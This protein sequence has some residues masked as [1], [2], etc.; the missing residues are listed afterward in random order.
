M[1]SCVVPG[2]NNHSAKTKKAG[3]SVSYFHIPLDHRTKAWLDRIRRTNLPPLENC[4]VCS[5]HFLPSCF[6]P[7]L[8]AQLTGQTGKRSLRA[9]AI[10]SIFKYSHSPEEK[11]PRLSVSS[12]RRLARQRHGEVSLS[13]IKSCP[14]LCYI[15]GLV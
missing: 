5:E 13:S 7:D 3:D 6:E 9:D 12:E 4:H 15:N 1:V 8:R 2:C 10:P 14:E 11:I